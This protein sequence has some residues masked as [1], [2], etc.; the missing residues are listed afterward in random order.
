MAQSAALKKYAPLEEEGPEPTISVE[1]NLLR[2]ILDRAVVDYVNREGT[3]EKKD[4]RSAARWLF[5]KPTKGWPISFWR[6]CEELELCPKT[7]RRYCCHWHQIAKKGRELILPSLPPL[8]IELTV[9][10]S[11]KLDQSLP[12]YHSTQ[13]PELGLEVIPEPQ[14]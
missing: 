13:P 11:P 2:A 9:D 6:I 14:L 12:P 4:H 8:K 3:I 10:S 1:E 5:G 7:I